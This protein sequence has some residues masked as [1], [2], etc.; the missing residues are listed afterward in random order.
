MKLISQRAF[1]NK[2][3]L[4]QIPEWISRVEEKDETI[5]NILK[6]ILSCG[7]RIGEVLN[8]Y[9]Y[10]EN[11]E[12]IIR[13]L[14][15]KKYSFTK[16][17]MYKRG[18]LGERFLK[19][20]LIKKVWKSVP[21]L[22]IFK[23]DMAF[24]SDI[25]SSSWNEPFFPFKMKYHTLYHRLKKLPPFETY[26]IVSK[27]ETPKKVEYTPSFHFFRKAFTVKSAEFFKTP[28]DLANYMKWDKLDMVL[29]YY[30]IY[31]GENPASALSSGNIYQPTRS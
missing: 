1:P 24:V 15:E 20:I 13:G 28:M 9:L 6:T 4:E 14:I 29:Q 2:Q 11:G 3:S 12:V 17:K 10:E 18:F 23:L 8:S 5:A 22:N 7:F 21:L 19:N 31:K 26:Y 30:R 16:M 27:Y 25:I